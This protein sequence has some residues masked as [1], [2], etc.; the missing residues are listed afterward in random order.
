[1]CTPWTV[2]ETEAFYIVAKFGQG[3]RRRNSGQP[4]AAT[5]ISNFRLLAGLTSF[6]SSRYLLHFDSS[7]PDGT[8]ELRVVSIALL[9]DS[10]RSE[11]RGLVHLYRVFSR[12]CPTLF[13]RQLDSCHNV[14]SR[15]EGHNIH[16]IGKTNNFQ[17]RERGKRDVGIRD[18]GLARVFWP[19]MN[20]EHY[21]YRCKW[22]LAVPYRTLSLV[23][24]SRSRVDMSAVHSANASAVAR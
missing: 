4:A 3:R 14:G 24:S 15:R 13:Y 2:L 16:F 8:F 12:F 23:N 1:M 9:K 10:S 7:R 19:T 11:G 20:S 18:P 21:I 6:D 17:L 5:R 22:S